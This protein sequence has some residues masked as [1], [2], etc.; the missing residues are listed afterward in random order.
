MTRENTGR[1]MMCDAFAFLTGTPGT[2]TTKSSENWF[3]PM[4]RF[5]RQQGGNSLYY[6]Q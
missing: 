6:C 3:V 4:R 1:K 5:L 2:V